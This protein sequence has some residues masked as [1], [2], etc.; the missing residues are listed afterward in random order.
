MSDTNEIDASSTPWHLWAVGIVAL[1]WSAGGG[2]DYYMTQ[3][4]NEA[5][6]SNFSPEQMEYFLGFPGWVV[7]AWAVAVWGGVLGSILLLLRRSEAVWVYLASLSCFVISVIYNYGISNG[8][9]VVGD[10]FNLIFTAVIFV[11]ALAFF[12]YARWM[13]DRGVL[14]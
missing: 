5:H 2:Y 6:L 9:D 3:T 13:R 12:L 4:Q 7:A 11:L 14:N 10:T 8:L 1:L